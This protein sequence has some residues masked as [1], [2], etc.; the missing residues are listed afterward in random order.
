LDKEKKMSKRRVTV[1]CGF[2]SIVLVLVS[3]QSVSGAYVTPK[4]GGAQR[5]H[6]VAPMIM[7]EITFDGTNVV[8]LDIMGNDWVTLTGNDRPVMWPLQGTDQFE[9]GKPW[10]NALNGKAYNFQYGWSNGALDQ[11]L[12]PAGDKIWIELIS[13][14]V[15]LQ[16]YNR[17]DNSYAPI[18]GTDGSSN[19][20]KWDET[21]S[22]AHNAY[23]VTPCYGEWFATYKVYIGDVTTGAELTSYGSDTVMLTWTSIP[24]PATLT[25]MGTGLF[26]LFGS[27]RKHR[28]AA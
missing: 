16:T 8:V 13:Q 5:T 20:W 2:I 18:F 9:P 22:M 4:I 1:V 11:T 23:A 10:Y 15:G 24:E 21:M 26:Y 19:L 7:P 14:S 6:V 25:L 28:A 12:I 17:S 3:V 27:R